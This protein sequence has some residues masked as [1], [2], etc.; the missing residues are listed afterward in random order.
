MSKYLNKPLEIELDKIVIGSSLEALLCAFY[1]KFKMVYTR[2]QRPDPY[3]IIE[4]YGLGT[5]RRD[6]W[7]KHMFQMTL[8]GYVPF[9][10]KIRHIRYTDKNTI[11]V[12][13]HEDNVHTVKFNELY[14]FDD[15]NFMDIPAS[16]KK[17]NDETRV[18]DTL[19]VMEGNLKELT[20][21]FNKSKFLNQVIIEKDKKQIVCISYL[22]GKK[23]DETPESLVRIKTESFLSDKK[24]NITLEHIDRKIYPL[25]KEIYEDFDNVVFSYVPEELMYKIRKTWVKIDY[26]KYL[27]IK[28]GIA[29]DRDE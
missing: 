15:Y 14:V 26:K 28:L 29:N 7:D 16:T 8:A 24:N 4:D 19:K 12:I 21:S 13:T 2:T 25:G 10:E 6:A 11:K 17:T 22:K 20:S 9:G 18:V 23:L 27:R 3:D 5:S 1:N